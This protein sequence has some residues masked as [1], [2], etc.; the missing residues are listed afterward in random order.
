MKAVCNW[1]EGPD[2]LLALE[3]TPL[4]LYEA[5][6]DLNKAVHGYVSQGSICLTEDEAE[7]LG[8]ELLM[9][10]KKARECMAEY[11]AYCEA[12]QKTPK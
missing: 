3:G 11:G 6:V 12:E 8:N 4:M 7:R 10:A 1:G 5:P 2:V 9:M